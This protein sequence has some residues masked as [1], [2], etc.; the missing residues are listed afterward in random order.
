MQLIRENA[1]Q[2]LMSVV[3]AI[4]KSR[5]S[6]EDWKCLKIDIQ[7]LEKNVSVQQSCAAICRVVQNDMKDHEGMLIVAAEG[8]IAVFCK[9]LSDST[10]QNIGRQV[11]L[12]ASMDQGIVVDFVVLDVRRDADGVIDILTDEGKRILSHNGVIDYDFKRK[13]KIENRPLPQNLRR[14]LL[15]EDDAVT[16]WIV[17]TTLKEECELFT[18]HTGVTALVAYRKYKP[19][20]VFLDIDLP[21]MSGQKVLN[22]ILEDDPGAYVVMFSSHNS[23]SNIT[24]LLEEGAKGFIAKPFNRDRLLHYI[25]DC[26]KTR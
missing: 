2:K 21:G 3:R 20:I 19:D 16:R 5:D 12:M 6:W 23:I 24:D 10:M 15:V 4:R 1:K 11:A 17:R 14:V 9:N 26:P 22:A 13:K 25:Q 8:D 18:A 7:S